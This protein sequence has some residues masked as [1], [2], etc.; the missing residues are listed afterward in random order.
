MVQW[1]AEQGRH[2]ELHEALI[3]AYFTEGIDIGSREQL[4]A[5]CDRLGFDVDAAA[6][7]LDSDELK[8]RVRQLEAR[9]ARNLDFKRK[10]DF[11]ATRHSK[12]SER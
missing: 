9:V 6:L 7:A 10:R 12:R 2:L 5:L 4:L 8:A 3:R 11:L 1:A